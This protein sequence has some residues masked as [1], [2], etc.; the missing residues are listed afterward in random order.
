MIECWKIIVIGTGGRWVGL[1]RKS[2]DADRYEM[3]VNA[4][5]STVYARPVCAFVEA[6]STATNSAT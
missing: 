5:G 4:I 3:R 1:Q 2:T 6:P